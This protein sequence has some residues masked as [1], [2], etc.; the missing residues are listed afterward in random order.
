MY[1]MNIP[2]CVPEYYREREEREQEELYREEEREAQREEHERQME[3]MD[4]DNYIEGDLDPEAETAEAEE[5]VISCNQWKGIPKEMQPKIVPNKLIDVGIINV[6]FRWE[7]QVHIMDIERTD[8]I[9]WLNSYMAGWSKEQC[10]NSLIAKLQQ[11][12]MTGKIRIIK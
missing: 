12:H 3:E 9:I 1:N 7:N 4:D 6:K 11:W 8:Q 5:Y 10:I 2:N